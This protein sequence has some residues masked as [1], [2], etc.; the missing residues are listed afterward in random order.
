VGIALQRFLHQQS[1]PIEAFALM[2]S[3]T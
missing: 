3:S 1:Q 2:W